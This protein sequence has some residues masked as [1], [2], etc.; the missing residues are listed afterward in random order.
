VYPFLD[1]YFF[2]DAEAGGFF[3]LAAGGW[4]GRAEGVDVEV[5]VE[6]VRVEVVC[7]RGM[8]CR[9]LFGCF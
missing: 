6:E 2:F 8:G 5:A 1:F 7:G 4:A 3:A 9:G